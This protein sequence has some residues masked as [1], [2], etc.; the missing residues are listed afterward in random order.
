M[1]FLPFHWA[2]EAIK[3]FPQTCTSTQINLPEPLAFLSVSMAELST[4][5]TATPALVS[6]ILSALAYEGHHTST[7]PHPFLAF[8][9]LSTNFYQ[10][11]TYLLKKNKL[12]QFLHPPILAT[13][14]F[15]HHYN[16]TPR[17]FWQLSVWT[18]MSFLPFF[19]STYSN[20]FTKT[21]LTKVTKNLH[22][23]KSNGKFVG[24]LLLE[25]K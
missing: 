25:H 7:F 11:L 1:T 5:L 23:A 10:M 3:E 8:I 19:S 21:A 18:P 13:N 6:S 24:P 22:V 12:S 4:L 15:A 16:K 20:Y 2:K 17:Q 14:F 9:S